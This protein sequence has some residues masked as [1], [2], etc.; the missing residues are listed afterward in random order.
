MYSLY[1]I[2]TKSGVH[3]NQKLT[4]AKAPPAKIVQLEC[5]KSNLEVV[6]VCSLKNWK[7]DSAATKIVSGYT[8]HIPKDRT[9][10]RMIRIY[11]YTL[12]L[13]ARRKVLFKLVWQ[14]H[15]ESERCATESSNHYN[16][17]NLAPQQYMLET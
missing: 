7:L 11:I 13:L 6:I 17:S 12:P 14:S 4:A 16:N 2:Q 5:T 15:H 10:T 1:Q 8:P 3:K 9:G